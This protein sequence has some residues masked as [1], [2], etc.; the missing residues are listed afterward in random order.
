MSKKYKILYS[1]TT[2]ILTSIICGVI[3]TQLVSAV[4]RNK[5]TSFLLIDS[6][7]ITI[8]VVKTN[9]SNQPL[10][11]NRNQA[12]VI[13]GG[14]SLTYF[15]D[16][17]AGGKD[18]DEIIFKDTDCMTPWF[19]PRW[20]GNTATNIPSLIS[21]KWYTAG[22]IP[23]I[24]SSGI[25]STSYSLLS[26]SLNANNAH[27][28]VCVPASDYYFDLLRNG[29]IERGREFRE[30]AISP[31]PSSLTYPL[32]I[33]AFSKPITDLIF[34][35]SFGTCSPN[36]RPFGCIRFSAN[37]PNLH[38]DVLAQSPGGKPIKTWK[39][40][41]IDNWGMGSVSMSNET[42]ESMSR[43][44]FTLIYKGK[45]VASLP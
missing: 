11:E 34:N 21:G 25:A 35:I 7:N 31:E 42:P 30:L 45:I 44:K 2:I 20:T 26:T 38:V 39:K 27:R 8:G 40:Q 24:P 18:S 29:R 37:C 23:T 28:S 17:P 33:V 36:G 10:T 12:T 4:D 14:Y 43:Y 32:R 15:L 1:V 41:R 13:T 3:N 16:I 6:N 22:P 9:G 19:N 5:N